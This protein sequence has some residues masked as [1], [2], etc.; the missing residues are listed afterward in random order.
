MSLKGGSGQE[1]LTDSLITDRAKL[2]LPFQFGWMSERNRL[3]MQCVTKS[4]SSF[5]LSPCLLIDRQ[6][7]PNKQNTAT[8]KHGCRYELCHLSGPLSVPLSHN[9]ISV[10]VSD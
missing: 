7:H 3:G 10:K 9:G 4:L 2:C 1:G 5:L 6:F 8:T